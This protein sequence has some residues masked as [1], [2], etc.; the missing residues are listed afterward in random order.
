MSVILGFMHVAMYA[1]TGAV[2][3]PWEA[4]LVIRRRVSSSAAK[5]ESGYSLVL[6]LEGQHYRPQKATPKLCLVIVM[7]WEGET[8]RRECLK[9]KVVYDTCLSQG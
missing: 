3:P 7:A 8:E 2:P 5:L 4:L 1:M 9:V 6:G